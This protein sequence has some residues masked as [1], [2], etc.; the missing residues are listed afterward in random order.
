METI[1]HLLPLTGAQK[2]SFQAAAPE[3]EHLFLPTND[4]GGAAKMER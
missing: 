3:S 4:R 1:L 2:A